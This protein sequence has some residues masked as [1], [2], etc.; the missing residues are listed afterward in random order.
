MKN[1]IYYIK[2]SWLLGVLIITWSINEWA[3]YHLEKMEERRTN[4][5]TN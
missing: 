2:Y 5:N 1:I 3:K 4:G